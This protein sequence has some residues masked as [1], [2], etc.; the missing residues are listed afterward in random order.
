[1][2]RVGRPSPLLTVGVA[3]AAVVLVVL[4]ATGDSVP[5]ATEGSGGWH[6]GLRDATTEPLPLTTVAPAAEQFDRRHEPG[7]SA[8]SVMAQ[9]VVILI[10]ALSLLVV[11]RALLRMARSSFEPLDLGP[12]EQ[13]P[14]PAQEIADAVDESL[15]ALA[16]GPIDEVVIDCWVRLES[17]AAA[18][19]AARTVSETP[20]ELA[21]RVLEDLHAPRDAVDDLLER[22]RRA[23]YSH[24]PL[25]EHDREVAVRALQRIR[26]ALAGAAA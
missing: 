16:S 2:V 17:A 26:D 12:V 10:G 25:D 15:A 9:T 11:G 7:D 20:A 5:L 4:V 1:M 14:E 21:S 8:L 23:R 18:A 22:Y 19:G 13:W 3:V 24:H 6:V